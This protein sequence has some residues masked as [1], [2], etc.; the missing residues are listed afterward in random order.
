ME[1]TAARGASSLENPA[2]I[3]TQIMEQNEKKH[4]HTLIILDPL[5]TIIARKA[6]PSSSSSAI[7]LIRIGPSLEKRAVKLLTAPNCQ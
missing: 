5:S 7:L 1:G 6:S 3:T 2:Y 4:V